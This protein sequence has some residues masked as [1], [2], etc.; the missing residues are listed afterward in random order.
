M[1]VGELARRA[2]L[3][4]DAIRFYERR[5]LLPSPPRTPS[6]YR[7]FP[8]STLE[9]LSF[10]RKGQALG[11]RLAEIQEIIELTK[12]GQRPCEQVRVAIHGRLEE[13]TD[14]IAELRALRET[15][16]AA[17]ARLDSDDASSACRCAAIDGQE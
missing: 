12:L 7:D 1:R 6:G 17:L 5:G 9:D 2:G 3:T 8:A 11:L 10:I 4:P 15:L 13:V 14:R 16:L